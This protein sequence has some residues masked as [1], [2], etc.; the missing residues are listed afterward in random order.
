MKKFIIFFS[1]FTFLF[2]QNLGILKTHKNKS[3]LGVF[4]TSYFMYKSDSDDHNIKNIP[5]RFR[6]TINHSFKSN[7]GIYLTS[8]YG[9]ASIQNESVNYY[10]TTIG[11]RY[12]IYKKRF[13]A[14]I[15][16][17][18]NEWITSHV[19]NNFSD[20]SNT[21]MS[22]TLY[23]KSK[24]HP[25]FTFNNYYYDDNSNGEV[26]TFG[27]ITQVNHY[28]MHWGWS[29]FFDDNNIEISKDNAIFF[30]G[31]GLEFF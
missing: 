5:E 21:G 4:L 8:G 14:S 2:S 3:G 19:N 29:I 7:L 24:Y 31:A 20:Y 16:I 22:F 9:D 10:N 11:A 25:Y 1:F 30:I 23:S 6:I 18:K 17:S 15:G 28:I 13:G 12:H 27:G 26:V